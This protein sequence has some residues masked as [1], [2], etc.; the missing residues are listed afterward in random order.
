[1]KRIVTFVLLVQ[2]L[3]TAN[4]QITD[5]VFA[6][7][8][9]KSIELQNTKETFVETYKMAMQQFVDNGT[10]SATNLNLFAND[11]ADYIIPLLTDR[12]EVL[13]YQNLTLDELKQLNEYLASSVGQKMIKLTP[14][15]SNEGMKV[16]QLP[17]VQAKIQERI[18]YYLSK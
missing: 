1:M 4:A 17:E 11:I 5:R 7:E 13:Y 9:K 15:F 3:F 16:A 18:T 12:M 2:A 14:L 8:V 10:L 6:A